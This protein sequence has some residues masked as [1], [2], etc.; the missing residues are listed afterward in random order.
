MVASSLLARVNL[1]HAPA[2][3]VVVSF[4][5]SFAHRVCVCLRVRAQ[6][7]AASIDSP[8]VHLAWVKTPRRK[9]GLGHMA[10]PLVSDV[11]REISNAYGVLKHDAGIAFRGLFIINPTGVLEHITMN[12]F[13]VGRSVDETLRVLQV[14]EVVSWAL[15]LGWVHVWLAVV[16]V[17]E[18]VIAVCA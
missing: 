9:G 12:N 1:Q 18:R 6:V 3:V 17:L 5:S 10:I 8:Q 2:P 15:L 11:T 4:A 13:P 7:I 16:V 14:G